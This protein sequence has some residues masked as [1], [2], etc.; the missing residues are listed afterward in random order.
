VLIPA[1]RDLHELRGSLEVHRALIEHSE[2]RLDAY[3]RFVASVDKAEPQ[4]VRRLAASQ[5]NKMPAD[6]RPYL[7]LPS[8]NATVSEWIDASEPLEVP[9][10][11]PYPDTLLSRL[12]T[13]PRRLWVLASGVFLIFVGFV[14]GPS[15]ARLRPAPRELPR[16]RDSRRPESTGASGVFV[17]PVIPAAVAAGGVAGI[18]GVTGDAVTF[19]ETAEIDVERAD[20]LVEDGVDVES[21]TAL[22]ALEQDSVEDVEDVEDV[23]AVSG[24]HLEA[25]TLVP[26][27]VDADASSDEYLAAIGVAETVTPIENAACAQVSDVDMCS[28]VEG[29]EI[30]DAAA[31]ALEDDVADELEDEVELASESEL[32]VDAEAATVLED[33]TG[34]SAAAVESTPEALVSSTLDAPLPEAAK[35]LEDVIDGVVDLA[36]IEGA[37]LEA[38]T[39]SPTDEAGTPEIVVD[40]EVEAP[41]DSDSASDSASDAETRADAEPTSLESESSV[42]DEVEHATTYEIVDDGPALLSDEVDEIS[43]EQ[44][45]DDAL[46]ADGIERFRAETDEMPGEQELPAHAQRPDAYDRALDTLSLFH[47]IDDSRWIDTSDPASGRR[48][49]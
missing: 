18:A 23:E 19:D 27:D 33:E 34:I 38:V 29:C 5:L 24:A 13:G 17:A 20:A 48:D 39:P 16:V 3:D 30:L 1:Q 9:S 44:E 41:V 22:G 21:A 25:A 32:A 12:A 46:E 11:A 42:E 31:T 47:G 28:D 10:P 4:L 15:G 2:R 35:S 36:P 49:S 8:M 14:F 37:N 26:E 40:L 6:E 43:L 7:M 45:G